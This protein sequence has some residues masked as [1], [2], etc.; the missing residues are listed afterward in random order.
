M[1]QVVKVWSTGIVCLAL[2]CGSKEVAATDAGGSLD[3]SSTDG[4]SEGSVDTAVSDGPVGE[5]VADGPAEVGPGD[6][7][8]VC[9]ALI[10]ALCGAESKGCCSKSSFPF[11]LEACTASIRS[12]CGFRMDQVEA[13]IVAFDGSKLDACVKGYAASFS[14]CTLDYITYMKHVQACS[15]LFNGT[16][17]PGDV[18]NPKIPDQCKAAPGSNAYCDEKL[19]RCRVYEISPL[20]GACNYSGT[21]TRYCDKGLFCDVAIPPATCKTARKTGDPCVG[22]GDLSCGFEGNVCKDSKCQPGLP[23]GATC[24]TF[25]ECASLSC[26]GGTCSA[27][28]FVMATASLCNGSGG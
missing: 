17:A 27:G 7:K 18:C 3:T 4:V 1:A 12:W 19:K 13:G 10:G 25:D 9:D 8:K 24:S 23:A 14:A 26:D 5:A 2:G 15:E 28:T 11:D 22:P 16:K 20:G 6:R 21:T